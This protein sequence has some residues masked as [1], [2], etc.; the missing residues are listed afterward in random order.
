MG[1]PLLGTLGVLRGEAGRSRHGRGSRAV[2][3]WASRGG[4]LSQ[5]WLCG[6]GCSPAGL[7]DP[8]AQPALPPLPGRLSTLS[9]QGSRLWQS[10]GSLPAA[11]FWAV[12]REG[13]SG[14]CLVPQVPLALAVCGMASLGQVEL[15]VAQRS[16]SPVPLLHPPAWYAED[17]Q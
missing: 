6:R 7:L 15:V 3:S 2:S 12:V 4:R 13:R 11:T 17:A 16:G 8:D 5:N 1:R 9:A 14:P 10:W